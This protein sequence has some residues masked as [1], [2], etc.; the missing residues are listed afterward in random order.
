MKKEEESVVTAAPTP[1]VPSPSMVPRVPTPIENTAPPMPRPSAPTEKVSSVPGPRTVV[2]VPNRYI[3]TKDMIRSNPEKMAA[4][5]DYMID[6]RG[7]QWRERSDEETLDTFVNHMRFVNTNEVS[8]IG[9]VRYTL[10]ADE[11]RK[12]KARKAYEAYDVLSN[13]LENGD[14]SDALGGAYQYTKATL[15]SPS[16]WLGAFVGGKLVNK[17][18]T[19]GAKKLILDNAVKEAV[20]GGGAAA[21]NEVIKAATKSKVKTALATGLIID[22]GASTFQDYAY[23]LSRVNVGAQDEY[24]FVEG[25]IATLGGVVGAGIA[26][27]PAAA[28]GLSGL[29]AAGLKMATS[30]KL[31]SISAGQTA[32]PKLEVSVKKLA[33]NLKDWEKMLKDGKLGLKTSQGDMLEKVGWFFDVDDPNSITR[34]VI[35]SGADIDLGDGV[36]FTEQIANFARDLPQKTLDDFNK[37]LKPTGVKFGQFLDQMAVAE[38]TSAQALNRASRAKKYATNFANLS[39]A[40]TQ[41]DRDIYKGMKDSLDL[42]EEEYVGPQ[43]ARYAASLWRR[44]LVSH[45]GT[46]ALN[47]IGWTQ[48]FGAK[49][50][51]EMIHGGTLGTTGFIGRMFNK[52]WGDKQ[53]ARSRALFQNQIYKT[54]MLL[55][56]YSTVDGFLDMVDKLPEKMRKQIDRSYFG[57]V[58]GTTS[59]DIYHM[60]PNNFFVKNAERVSDIA[61]TATFVKAQ[62]VVTKS[63]SAVADLDRLSRLHYGRGIDDLMAKGDSKLLTEEMWET[64]IHNMLKDT[65]SIDHTR[66]KGTL[67]M[68]AR[69]VEQISNAPYVGF[70][71]PFGRFMN[72]A[73]GFMMEY[74][75]LGLFSVASK[76]YNNKAFTYNAQ[77]KLARAV[78]GTTALY[79]L[80][81][82]SQGHEQQGLQWN[83]V[84]DSTGDITNK[85]NT[86]PE[87]MYRIVAKMSELYARGEGIPMEMWKELGNVLGPGQWSR[88]L[89][90]GNA[91]NEIIAAMS[92]SAFSDEDRAE[93][94]GV[95]DTL[96]KGD[97]SPVVQGLVKTGAGIASGYTRPL[98]VFNKLIGM[99]QE[100]DPMID[101]RMASTL[102]ETMTQELTRYTNSLFSPF[103]GDQETENGVPVIGTPKR[104][105]TRPEGDIHDPNPFST[106]FARREEPA[107]NN[108]DRVLGMVNL[109]PF[110]MDKRSAIPELDHFVNKEV[111]PIL[112][113]RAKN[114]LENA[115]WRNAPQYEKVNQV[116][117]MLLD[118][119]EEVIQNL[120][121]GTIGGPQVRLNDER[122]KWTASY[123]LS[124]REMARRELGITTPDRELSKMQLEVMKEYIKNR[125]EYLDY[126][127]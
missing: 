76:V 58:D 7:V 83:Q 51:A 23:Q 37:I 118:V 110:I 62:D 66:A 30:K 4:V 65:F 92:S 87:S 112:N 97:M 69:I 85:S 81:K 12:E 19:T 59:T 114:L 95:V 49:S 57:G 90:Q 11:Q 34:I 68:F 106:L 60:N 5:R 84:E 126:I 31:K 67:N 116:R 52:Q 78:V 108:I 94:M 40:N 22:S 1:A 124:E 80:F 20:K 50:I 56:P 123:S 36:R 117:Q 63:F 41:L 100:N 46:T 39:A 61:S 93:V 121:T 26:T 91:L 127:R 53:L 21:A 29:D 104:A 6:R 96:L 55:D 77:E 86:A 48:A 18:L 125:K 24:D 107:F 2:P 25:A 45:P 79:G 13:F 70:L 74:S 9:E 98:D 8:T 27:V 47:V 44:M 120:R 71:F 3:V 73:L 38:S 15:L 99:G 82:T 43:Y 14:V 28:R 72:N 101:R 102:S 54:K 75:P 42:P 64:A 35:D 88:Q 122:S 10:S 119:R 115:Q 89:T 113:R 111:A 105:A 103:L 109:P 33:K 32:A 17:A 16:S